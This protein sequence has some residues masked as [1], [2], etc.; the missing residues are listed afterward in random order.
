VGERAATA[1]M[2][3]GLA[4]MLYVKFATA[5]AWTWYVAIGTGVTVSIALLA[6]VALREE[7]PA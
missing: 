4:V 2:S 1:G 7:R 5:I 6:S 3:A